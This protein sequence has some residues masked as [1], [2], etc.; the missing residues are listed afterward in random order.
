MS[1][2]VY[3]SI[4]PHDPTL[5]KSIADADNGHPVFTTMRENIERIRAGLDAAKPDVIVMASGD[6]FNQ[7]FY[8]HVPTFAVGKGNT[9]SGP[10]PWELEVYGIDK[11]ETAGHH[12]LG[13]HILEATLDRSFDLC[14]SD[15]YNIDHGFTV[16]LNFVRPEQDIPV[17]PLWT[18]VLLPPLPPGRRY[19]DLGA[20]LRTVLEDFPEQLRVAVIGTG[21]MTNSV[22]GPAMLKFADHPVTPWDVRTWELFTTG[23]VEDLLPDCTWDKLY[24]QGNGTPGFMAHL[25]AWGV[26]GG[27][28][29]SWA[30]LTSAPVTFAQAFVE[31]DEQCLHEGNNV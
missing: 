30:A 12:D 31:W 11:Y 19:F 5:P 23:R 14:S 4:I 25:V 16:P 7:W 8:T 18:N 27:R 28:I 9:T 29:P 24:E 17:V 22:G 26:A 13:R 6:H 10:F 15:E 3:V 1:R 20:T 2:L 21:H